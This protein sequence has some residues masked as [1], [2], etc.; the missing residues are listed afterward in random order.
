MDEW[1][2]GLGGFYALDGFIEWIYGLGGWFGWING[3]MDW[4]D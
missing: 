3:Q 4:I 2:D 1:M